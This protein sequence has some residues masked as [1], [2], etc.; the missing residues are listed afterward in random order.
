MADKVSATQFA[1]VEKSDIETALDRLRGGVVPSGFA[2]STR[3]DLLHEG[4]RFSTKAVAALAVSR[5]LGRMPGPADFSGGE[6]AASTRV[7]LERGFEVVTKIHQ[8][9]SLDASFCLGRGLDEEFVIVESRGPDRNTQ[10]RAGLE[11][12]LVGLGEEDISILDAFV[13]SSRT[14]AAGQQR[15]SLELNGLRYP[16]RVSGRN[17]AVTLA[18]DLGRAAAAMGREPGATGSGNPTKRLRLVIDMPEGVSLAVLAERLAGIEGAPA[19]PSMEFGFVPSAPGAW[20]AEAERRATEPAR[21]RLHHKQMQ[22]DLYELL[23]AEY[24]PEQVAAEH[25]M[26]SGMPADLVANPP[27]GLVIFEVKTSKTPRECVREALGQLLEYGYWPGSKEVKRLVVVG[28]SPIDPETTRY[29]EALVGRFRLPLEY[30]Q[31]PIRESAIE[32]RGGA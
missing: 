7:L 4:R 19:A 25:A 3:Y 15:Q 16:I 29:L 32:A 20:Q 11:Q 17:D 13:D 8:V 10:Y 22:K 2:D 23:V 26:A 24:G 5:V 27:G 18:Q 28:P 9:G 12:I 30:L 21:V 1:L 14:R 31:Q 6:A